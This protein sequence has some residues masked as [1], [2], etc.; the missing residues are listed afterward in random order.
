MV[1][2]LGEKSDFSSNLGFGTTKILQIK[3]FVYFHV[4]LLKTFQNNFNYTSTPN[5]QNVMKFCDLGDQSCE[6]DFNGM[7]P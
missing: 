7:F 1:S 2:L 6:M 4:W 3:I 5:I